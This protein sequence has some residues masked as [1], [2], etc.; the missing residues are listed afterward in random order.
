MLC[1]QTSH[2]VTLM[3]N[4]GNCRTCCPV[5]PG[6]P[7][8]PTTPLSPCK[9]KQSETHHKLPLASPRLS[10]V[11]IEQYITTHS[12][13]YTVRTKLLLYICLSLMCIYACIDPLACSMCCVCMHGWRVCFVFVSL[14]LCTPAKPPVPEP[15]LWSPGRWLIWKYN[16][17]G[18][19]FISSLH[20]SPS[21]SISIPTFISTASLSAPSC[22]ST[23][24]PYCSGWSI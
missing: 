11:M 9:E 12:C 10:A 18:Q 8:G 3:D 16:H 7:L 22:N 20:Q 5:G 23:Q 2:Y 17:A 6:G 15:H 21:S 13:W 4:N 19:D 24:V 1:M 14:G